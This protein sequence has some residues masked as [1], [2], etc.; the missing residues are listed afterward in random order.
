MIEKI[1][2]IAEKNGSIE[3]SFSTR[4]NKLTEAFN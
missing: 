4:L 1:D 2:E 3:K